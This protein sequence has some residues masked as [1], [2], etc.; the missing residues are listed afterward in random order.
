[1]GHGEILWGFEIL[2]GGDKKLFC[3]FHEYSSIIMNIFNIFT[4]NS[5]IFTKKMKKKKAKDEKE[6]IM[7][8][9]GNEVKQSYYSRNAD[10]K[11][12]NLWSF[13]FCL[14]IRCFIL[15]A[16]SIVYR[17]QTDCR[18]WHCPGALLLK[19][20]RR[21]YGGKVWTSRNMTQRF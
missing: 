8:K 16:F 12:G 19:K 5:D 14:K 10:G 18:R 4:K 9:T 17:W 1:M 7:Y 6:S 3:T 13:C 15:S 21:E 2:E 20:F 11:I